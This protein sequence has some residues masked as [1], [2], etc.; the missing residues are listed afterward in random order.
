[1]GTTSKPLHENLAER[2][3]FIEVFTS[4]PALFTANERQ[5]VTAVFIE[6][7]SIALAAAELD[8]NLHTLAH[9]IKAARATLRLWLKR[10]GRPA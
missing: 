10:E 8:V 6:R 2:E 7:R 5:G 1:M 9:R 3:A 4:E